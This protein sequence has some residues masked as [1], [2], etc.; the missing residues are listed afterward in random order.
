MLSRGRRSVLFPAPLVPASRYTA[1][2]GTV[3]ST[4]ASAVSRPKRFTSPSVRTAIPCG[5]SLSIL[6]S[7]HG[8]C[9]RLAQRLDQ[10]V[11]GDA[12]AVGVGNCAVDHFGKQPVPLGLGL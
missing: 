4:P 8:S 10:P 1:P 6:R 12:V 5:S 7:V 9:G 3:R 2:S 11:R